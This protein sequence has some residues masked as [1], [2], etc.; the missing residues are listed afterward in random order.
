MKPILTA[1]E[2]KALLQQEYARLK[3]DSCTSCKIPTPFWGPGVVTGTGYW[4]LKMLPPCSQQCGLVISGI[5]ASITTDYQIE[6]SEQESGMARY[7]GALRST[8]EGEPKRRA[9][10]QR[11]G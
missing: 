5:W 2:A 10:K 7:R 11:V 8:A 3:P 6:R 9:Q 4:Y 1:A